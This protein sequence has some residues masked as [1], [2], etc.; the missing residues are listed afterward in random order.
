MVRFLYLLT[1]MMETLEARHKGMHLGCVVLNEDVKV[2]TW[3]H[4]FE[5]W[6]EGLESRPLLL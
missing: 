5:C 3:Y 1:N 6:E 4:V 2:V